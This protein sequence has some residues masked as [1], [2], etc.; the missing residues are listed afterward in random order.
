MRADTLGRFR[1]LPTVS[2]GPFRF[3]EA[4]PWLMFAT[5]FRLL[6]YFHKPTALPAMALASV[7]L[8]LAFLLMARRMIELAE[9]H[10]QLGSLTFLDQLTLATRLLGR[11]L[12]VLIVGSV[13]IGLI[14]PQGLAPHMM[15]GFDGIAF[16]QFTNAGKIW[17]SFLAAVILLMIVGA[18]PGKEVRL[19]AA[20]RE[21]AWRW[22]W[23]IPA[24]LAVAIFQLGLGYIQ[25]LGRGLVRLFV[26]TDA[27][28][29]V[30]NLLYF[31]FIFLFAAIR[32]WG[33]LAIL[34]FALR[35]SYRYQNLA[36]AEIA[37]GRSI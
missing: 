28:V 7:S 31:G 25:G 34:T 16:D 18:G 13:G 35:E 5:A 22:K 12:L 4:V 3:L 19:F 33:T 10:T 23:L 32:L 21:L 17:S 26:Q 2:Y 9:G 6:A 24:V 20:L 27:P 1:N 29:N 11:V 30:K 37:D 8:L 15:L 36:T 14:G